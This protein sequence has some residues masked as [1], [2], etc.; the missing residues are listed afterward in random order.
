MSEPTNAQSGITQE[1]LNEMFDAYNAHDVDAVLEFFAEDAIFDHAI[2]SD[3]HGQRF[4]GKAAIRDIFA[5]AFDSVESLH[6][7]P[8]DARFVGDKAYCEQHRTSKLKTGEFSDLLIIDILTFRDGLFVHKDT[9]YKQ[10]TT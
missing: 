3:V 7:Q 9:Y 2:G 4:E 5:R 1:L 6:Y 10:R 8:I